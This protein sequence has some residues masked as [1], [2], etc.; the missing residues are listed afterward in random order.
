MLE[1]IETAFLM[2]ERD[3]ICKVR[4]LPIIFILVMIIFFP[5]F[6]IGQEK[7]V[8][9]RFL[10]NED[11]GCD[12]L[13][14]CYK[15][16]MKADVGE[17]FEFGGANVRMYFDSSKLIYQSM[18]CKLTG[19]Y[20]ECGDLATVSSVSSDDMWGMGATQF[21]QYNILGFGVSGFGDVI[22]GDAYTTFA[23]ICFTPTNIPP[24]GT[25]ICESLVWDR[26]DNSS[27]GWQSD[28][29]L[30][31][32][33]PPSSIL[34]SLNE[35]PTHL[36]WQY[37][38]DNTGELVMNE[39]TTWTC[40][41]ACITEVSTLNDSGQ[42]SLRDAVG[43]AEE[44]DTI[45]FNPSLV[46]QTILLTSEK[47]VIG[48]NLTILHDQSPRVTIQS[49]TSGAFEIAPAKIVKFQNLN[50]TSGIGGIPAAI[51]NHGDLTLQNAMIIRNPGLPVNFELLV[52]NNGQLEMIGNVDVKE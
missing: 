31:F 1:I 23:E 29:I 11:I 48:K 8:H 45:T 16:Q 24:A 6:V 30:F 46:G 14:I 9:L 25:D 52:L 7:N 13:T 15:L 32:E 17:S 27:V 21:V 37:L 3:K 22:L 35:V 12:T 38:T 36:N 2:S 50:I 5:L 39:C 26:L 43:C 20:L 44:G 19:T 28:G 18:T 4:A 42:G 40:G 47:I 10:A 51:L 49:S 41:T 33:Q 34:T